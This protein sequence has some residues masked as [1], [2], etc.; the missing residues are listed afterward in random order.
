MTWSELGGAMKA[1]A[2]VTWSIKYGLPGL[3]L[4]LAARRGEPVAR[5]FVEPGLREDPFPVYDEIRARGP[6]VGGRF[7]S[8][9][10]SHAVANELLRSDVFRAD[11]TPAPSPLLARL[12]AAASDPRALGPDDAPSLL[13]IAPPQ[14]T[15]I[16]R[17]VSHAFTARAMTAL[18]TRV[19]ELAHGMLDT[20]AAGRPAG[21]PVSFDLIDSYAGLLPVTVIAEMLG[22]PTSMRREFLDWG[23]QAAL[24][25]EPG[26]SW[27][28][29]R[30]AYA[31]NR[32]GH[33]WLAEHIARLRRQPGDDLLSRMIE[34]ADGSDRL[35]DTELH[36]TA[37]LIL[38][39][40]FETTVNLIGNAVA[41]LL[42]HPDQL[43]ALTAEPAGWGNAIEEVLRYDSP[44]QVTLR[45]PTADTEVAG[46]PVAARV[47]VVVLLGAANRDP[48]VFADP[49]RFDTTRGNAREHLA[50]SA[51]I[52]FCLGAQLARLEATIAVRALF[53]RFPDL[54]V[55]SRPT[56]RGTN[57][58]RGYR[59]LPLRG[60]AAA[61]VRAAP[62]G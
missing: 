28:D 4:R 59:R 42:A 30:R 25:L 5:A 14:H 11:P 10:A 34:A 48:D 40:G 37:L 44:V 39:A 56:R 52:H 47:P 23:G 36:I 17:L 16:R 46:I 55:A 15:R 43:A 21:E 33:V 27:R 13:A 57:V 50:F 20:I 22:V 35:S 53:D 6:L 2:A 19:A 31:A 51:G 54:V 62:L 12:L 3:G 8:A 24:S 60:T 41:L 7:V 26:L 9:T 1:R 38:G 61:A 49:H 45:T 18:S 32:Q 58:L 29:Y